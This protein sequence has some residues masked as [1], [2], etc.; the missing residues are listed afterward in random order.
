MKKGKSWVLENLMRKII[1]SF[2]IFYLCDNFVWPNLP[3]NFLL[4]SLDKD[5]EGKALEER[6][7]RG[8]I[9]SLIYHLWVYGI[10]KDRVYFI[11]VFLFYFCWL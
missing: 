9:G 4:C 8:I 7:Y 11:W 2:R 5:K 6:K 10:P 3:P 1:M